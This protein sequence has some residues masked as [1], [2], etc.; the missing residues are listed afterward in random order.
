MAKNQRNAKAPISP[1]QI[2]AS[3]TLVEKA[4]QPFVGGPVFTKTDR[5]HHLKMK[6]GAHQIIPM[7]ASLASK[8]GVVVPDLSPDEM[9]SSLQQA[10]AI[11]SLLGTVAVLHQTLKDTYLSHNADAWK[12]ATVTYAMLTSASRAKESLAQEL[13]PVKEWFRYRSPKSKEA[14][15][16]T[17]KGKRAA[18]PASVS[19]VNDVTKV[20]PIPVEPKA[21]VA[22]AN[23]M[24]AAHAVS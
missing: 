15:A 11:E 16:A 6:R 17:V 10:Q 5:L 7:I 8:Y 19:T 13:V 22:L 21:D 1:K 20:A 2:E 24:T 18:K 4:S 12:A 9:R 3:I 14:S 23:G